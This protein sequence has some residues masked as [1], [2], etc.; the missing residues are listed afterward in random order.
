MVTSKTDILM[1]TLG[2][3]SDR[4]TGLAVAGCWLAQKR[5]QDREDTKISNDQHQILILV[6]FGWRGYIGIGWVESVW[7][8]NWM[9]IGIC[10]CDSEL[11][12]GV[13]EEIQMADVF[14]SLK[15]VDLVIKL[16]LCKCP[17]WKK[18]PMWYRG[19]CQIYDGVA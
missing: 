8:A 11:R 4:G 15:D 16:R 5:K 6:G 17:V 1:S 10:D 2:N 3:Y 12:S 18:L 19:G 14:K 9:G 13:E 7:Y